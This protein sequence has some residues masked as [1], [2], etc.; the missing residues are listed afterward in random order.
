MSLDA[1]EAAQ[2]ANGRRDARHHIAHLELISPSDIPRF[3][4]LGVVANFQPLWAYADLYITKLTEPILGPQRSRLL[5]PI[6]SVARSGAVI[7]GGSDWSVSSMNPLEAIQI[8]VTRRALE[9]RAGTPWLPD[10]VVD[11]PTMIAAYTINGAYLSHQEKITGSI[12]MGKAADLIVLD[13]DLF[14]IPASEIHR[15]KVMLT[16]LEGKEVYPREHGQT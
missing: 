5:Y 7:A 1:I 10:E 16:L 11:L 2:K 3:K 12:E 4:E 15:V 6:G 9:D 14:E 13:H 8:G